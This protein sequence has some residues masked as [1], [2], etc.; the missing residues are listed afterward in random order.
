MEENNSNL[1]E[2]TTKLLREHLRG[3][4]FLLFFSNPLIA[5]SATE[6]DWVGRV[7][8]LDLQNKSILERVR[9]SADKLCQMEQ[10][11]TIQQQESIVALR[12]A[13]EEALLGN[14]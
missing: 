14:H 1:S 12:N 4:A 7:S 10:E 2:Q 6:T 5:E 8:G 13:L 11:N 3:E 9:D